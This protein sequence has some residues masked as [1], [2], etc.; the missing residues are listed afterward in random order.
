MQA[1]YIQRYGGPEVVQVGVLPAPTPGAG[2]LVFRMEA[3]SVNPVDF[4]TRNGMLRALQ[5]YRMPAILGNDAAGVVTALGPG[6]EGFAVGDRVAARLDKARMGAFA[7]FVPARQQDLAKIP[8]GVDFAPAAAVALAGLTAWQC[9]TEVLQVAPGE[10]VLI[11]AG[12]GGVGHLA[13]QLAKGL[14]AQVTTTASAASHD[15]LR[16]LG[17]DVCVD[18]RQADFR[19]ECAPFDAVLDTMGGETLLRSIT[20]TR[21]G[22]RVVSI[23]DLPTPEIAAEFAKPWLAPVFWLLSRKPRA[24]ARAQGVAYRYWFM[25]EDGAQLALLLDKI[26][27]GELRVKIDRELPLAQAPEAL[28][29]SETGGVHGK[30]A[31]L[32]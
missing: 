10:R 5:S 23:G 2:E 19:N 21:R 11:H 8:A 27:R 25:R 29:I 24:A 3:A 30:L 31:V 16:E 14:G 28:R 12:G 4:K 15:W 32:P 20:H 6:V 17:A 26:A 1:C 13:I 18:Y 22:G 7:E 9:L